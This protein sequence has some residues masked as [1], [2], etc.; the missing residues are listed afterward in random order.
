MLLLLCRHRLI[1]GLQ[2]LRQGLIVRFQLIF[3]PFN[4]LFRL[5]LAPCGLLLEPFSGGLVTGLGLTSL[6]L[7]LRLDPPYPLG[8]ARRAARPSQGFAL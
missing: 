1:L 2:L 6:F 4:L 8:A 3:Q 5:P 7:G